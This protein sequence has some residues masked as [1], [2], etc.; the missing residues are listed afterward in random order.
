MNICVF[1]A[2][3]TDIEQQYIDDGEK[4]G[5]KLAKAGHNLVF[6]GGD[7]GLMGA[8]ARGVKK[9]G[10]KIISIVPKMF[11]G[12]TV[13]TL[14]KQYDEVYYTKDMSARQAKMIELSD[15]FVITP[16]GIGT[17]EEFFVVLDLKQLEVIRKPI[18]VL[19]SHGYFHAL[20]AMMHIG[21]EEK[22]MRENALSLY[23]CFGSHE[24]RA[25]I[26]Y[27]ETP[28]EDDNIPVSGYKYG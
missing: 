16:G 22:F 19:N 5:Y 23:K 12:D 11:K 26:K 27:L 6:G 18:A 8:V 28:E 1:G 10:G 7:N 24:M 14:F 21:F 4:L 13:E 9:G 20:E 25:L 2:A 3:S 17:Y 15:G